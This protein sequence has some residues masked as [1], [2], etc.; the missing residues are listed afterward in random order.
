[1]CRL[2]WMGW[3]VVFF[4]SI[5]TFSAP[6]AALGGMYRFD[7]IVDTTEFQ[8]IGARAIPSIGESGGVTYRVEGI[9]TIDRSY[10]D[11]SEFGIPLDDSGPYQR[12]H[13][14]SFNKAGDSVVWGAFDDGSEELFLWANGSRT[15]IADIS[16]DFRSLG[17]R[18]PVN[19]VRAVAFVATK[20]D[21]SFESDG[22]IG[23]YAWIDGVTEAVILAG[24]PLDGSTVRNIGFHSY[25]SM[26]ALSEKRP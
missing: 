26:T 3:C 14:P 15:L 6:R 5:A 21:L 8:S 9:T 25:D 2:I 1:M 19:D 23:V 12:F 10:K 16:G 4:L 13:E 17:W 20:D 7:K 11:L 18:L 24:D 22:W